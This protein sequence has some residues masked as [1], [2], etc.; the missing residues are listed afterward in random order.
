MPRSTQISP[1]ALA[2]LERWLSAHHQVVSSGELGRLGIPRHHGHR[3][4]SARRWQ[5][6]HRGVWCAYT[7]PLTFHSRCA[8]ALAALGDDAALDADTAARLLGFR[9][10]EAAAVIRVVIPH[11]TRRK[12]LA[13]VQVRQSRTLTARSYDE[14]KGLRVVRI[15]RA[16]L[17][18]ALRLPKDITHIVAEVVQQGLTTSA[19]LRG[20]ALGLGVVKGR[21]R[22]LQA[23]DEAGGGARSGLEARFVAI[24]RKAR[25]PLPQQNFPL[26]IDG[27][28]I[29]LDV[30]FPELRI[31]I[32][33]DGKAYHLF[34]EDWENDLERQNDLV[35]DGWLVLRFSAQVIRDR[36]DLVVRRVT[37]ALGAR[38][39]LVAAGWSAGAA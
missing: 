5:R 35:L 37:K 6:V 7:G 39:A 14:R 38:A 15:E 1:A 34:S 13:G 4:E 2:R 25:L 19:R 12:T 36:P 27:R 32:E 18:M 31:A 22:L 24:L 21:R 17:A 10:A 23:I 3:Q 11:G 29:W 33:I 26:L 20:T 9:R 16:A 30:C 28:R 8:A